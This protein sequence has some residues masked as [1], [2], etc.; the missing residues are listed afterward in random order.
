[1]RFA[2]TL[3]RTRIVD[4]ESFIL[5]RCR[6]ARVLHLGCVDSGLLEERLSSGNFL[7]AALAK[8]SPDLWGVDLDAAGLDRL[9]REG[10]VN[11]HV[12]SAEA[13]PR[14]IPRDYF[15]VV[16]AGEL[17]EHVS[18]PGLLL[19]SSAACCNSSGVLLLTTPNGL[20]FSNV[21]SCVINTEIV[22]PEHTI[23][24]TPATLQRLLTKHHLD[25]INLLLFHGDGRV[26]VRNSRG[27]LD[28][29]LRTT[30]NGMVRPALRVALHL[31]PYFADGIIAVAKPSG[32]ASDE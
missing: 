13:I 20:R 15:D 8:E 23:T 17:I 9:K 16:L 10:F 27:L 3:P 31:F 19:D 24:F 2:S 28:V 11:L 21:V 12:G 1:M 26:Q 18:N 22:H 14:A 5:S 32:S 7:H 25:L 30:Y 6:G 29:V 4:R